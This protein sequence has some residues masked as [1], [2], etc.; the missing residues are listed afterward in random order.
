MCLLVYVDDIILVSS[1]VPVVDRLLLALGS[2]FVVKDLGTLHY[3]MGLE[4][5][6]TSMGLSLTRKKYS[7]DLLRRAGMLKCKLAPTT[8]AA[9][10]KITVVDGDPLSPDDATDYRS[11]VGGL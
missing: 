10:D 3:F 2:E 8:M 7:L 11:I 4:V 9:T 5:T 1:S 6:H